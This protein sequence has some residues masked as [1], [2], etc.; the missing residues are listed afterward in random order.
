L[1]QYISITF[2]LEYAASI[3]QPLIFIT[4]QGYF[5]DNAVK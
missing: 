5:C 1:L 3:I 2:E 4:T